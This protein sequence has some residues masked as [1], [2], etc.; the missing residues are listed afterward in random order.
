MIVHDGAGNPSRCRAATGDA[1][2]RTVSVWWMEALLPGKKARAA[3]VK[4]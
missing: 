1:A 2:L 4:P 3:M